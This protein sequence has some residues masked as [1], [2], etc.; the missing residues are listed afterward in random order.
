MI[1]H[2][3]QEIKKYIEQH[4]LKKGEV[5]DWSKSIMVRYFHDRPY[6]IDPS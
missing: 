3:F 4:L 5:L 2:R 6:F 1:I